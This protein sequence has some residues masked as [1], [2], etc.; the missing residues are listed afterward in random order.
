MTSTFGKS[1]LDWM[2]TEAI[3]FFVKMAVIVLVLVGVIWAD[4]YVEDGERAQAAATV[5]RMRADGC[6]LAALDIDHQGT[7]VCRDLT[8]QELADVTA[9]WRAD[10]GSAQP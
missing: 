2:R 8:R 3:S 6:R 10:Q 5:G 1:L 4:G 9:A 7:F